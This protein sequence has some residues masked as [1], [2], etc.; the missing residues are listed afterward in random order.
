VENENTTPNLYYL[1]KNSV[2]EIEL[3]TQTGICSSPLS[4]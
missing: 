3:E 4:N 2:A 1:A